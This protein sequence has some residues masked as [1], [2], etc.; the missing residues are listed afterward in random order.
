MSEATLPREPMVSI[1]SAT[2]FYMY[3]PELGFD[4]VE[5]SPRFAPPLGGGHVALAIRFPAAIDGGDGLGSCGPGSA[6]GILRPRTLDRASHGSD[7]ARGNRPFPPPPPISRSR[8]FTYSSLSLSSFSLYREALLLLLLL[9][10]ARVV[11]TCGTYTRR[12]EAC[13]AVDGDALS[14]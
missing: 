4:R 12:R 14:V 13:V 5:Y 10:L 7:R 3:R 11:C 2:D 8:S 6:R 1:G 9:L